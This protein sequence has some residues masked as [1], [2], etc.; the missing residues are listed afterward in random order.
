MNYNKGWRKYVRVANNHNKVLYDVAHNF[1]D[2]DRRHVLKRYLDK[3]NVQAFFLESIR[4]GRDTKK[5]LKLLESM[6]DAYAQL[7]AQK[8]KDKNV[9]FTIVV[10]NQIGPSQRYISRTIGCTKYLLSKAIT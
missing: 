1:N 7:V 9:F 10:S 3:E 2:E 6:K 4:H 5:K 8:T